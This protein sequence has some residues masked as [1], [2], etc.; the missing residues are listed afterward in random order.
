MTGQL[1]LIGMALIFSFG[2]LYWT[3][4]SQKR[5]EREDRREHPAE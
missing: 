4:W 5:L 1:I 2:G 3:R